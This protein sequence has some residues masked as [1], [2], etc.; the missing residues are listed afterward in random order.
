MFAVLKNK[1]V[2]VLEAN[3]L[4]QEVWSYEVEKFEGDPVATVTP[5]GNEGDYNTTEENVRLYSFNI[6]LFV[7][8]TIR[9]K[10]KADE[11][12]TDLI[13]SIIDDFDKDY[14]MSGIVNPTGYTFIN[15][16]VLPSKWG[17]AGRED[18]FRVGELLLKCRVS[19]DLTSL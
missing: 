14:A 6:R 5:S 2:S 17:Y 9:T 4:L 8:R 1:I 18:E 12:L 7:N 13:D 10:K 19:V 3:T 15:S 11:V 16:F